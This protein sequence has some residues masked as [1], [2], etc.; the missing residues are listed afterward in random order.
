MLTIFYIV[1]LVTIVFLPL[2]LLHWF[3]RGRK[4]SN[5]KSLLRQL[6]EVGLAQNLSFSCQEIIGTRVFGLDGRNRKLIVVEKLSFGDFRKTVVD[7]DDVTGCMVEKE[8]AGDVDD[9]FGAVNMAPVTSLSLQLLRTNQAPLDI[10]FYS[11]NENVFEDIKQLEKKAHYWEAIL[12]KL[13]LPQEQ[14]TPHV[15]SFKKK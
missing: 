13:I 9:L 12:S 4:I 8:V 1:L 5:E 14:Q 10:V 3:D 2:L 7:L 15:L 11:G 6:S